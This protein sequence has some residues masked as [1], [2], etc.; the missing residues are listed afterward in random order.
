M[1]R[2]KGFTLMELFT[3]IVVIFIMGA[4]LAPA[5]IRARQ[6]AQARRAEGQIHQLV[7]AL[8]MYADDWGTYPPDEGQSPPS[9]PP[10]GCKELIDALESTVGSGPYG[11]WTED[12]SS[13]NLLDP[14]E[15]PY[16]YRYNTGTVEGASRGIAF[17]IWSDGSNENNES[18]SGDDI[19][20]W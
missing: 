16:R 3:V 18:G 2:Q 6:T 15:N 8:R 14:W 20:N 1:G 5:L 9:D 7:I 19:R 10:S 12:Q 17:N 13:D 4:V 11:E